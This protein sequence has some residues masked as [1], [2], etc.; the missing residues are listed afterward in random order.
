VRRIFDFCVN[1]LYLV[2]NLAWQ[3]D[4]RGLK[5]FLELIQS[6]GADEG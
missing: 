1:P 2:E 6:G 3:R 5:F 4:F